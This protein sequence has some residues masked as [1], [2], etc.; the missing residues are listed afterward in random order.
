VPRR[1]E[2]EA[3][4]GQLLSLISVYELLSFMLPGAV[5]AGAAVWA[6]E[7][8][9]PNLG[10]PGFL[11]VLA[12]VYVLGLFLQG[13]SSIWV[14]WYWRARSGMPSN[15]R[16]RSGDS[17]AYPEAM[18]NLIYAQARRYWPAQA[19]G[20]TTA[21][22][23][24]LARSVLR[25]KGASARGELMEVRYGTYR[26]LTSAAA[27]VVVILLVGAIRSGR[28]ET[29]VEAMTGAVV[30]TFVF[31]IRFDR[32]G[33]RFADQA[34]GDFAALEPVGSCRRTDH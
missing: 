29:S 20:F 25:A 23:F 16:M 3:S 11:A 1:R 12:G 30:A 2:L 10:L 7:R 13:L 21:N 4:T 22:I 5:V 6:D 33:W 8:S 31:G 17:R 15:R 34:W 24:S 26:G 9:V 19:D 14:A 32:F 28:W 18:Q 27:V